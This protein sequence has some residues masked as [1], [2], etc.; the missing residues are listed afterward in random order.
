[1]KTHINDR[2]VVIDSYPQSASKYKDDYAIVCVD[3]IRSATTAITAVAKGRRCFPV[4]SLD[5]AIALSNAI[6]DDRPLLVGELGGRTPNGIGIANSPAAVAKRDDVERPLI[7]LSTSGT[8]LI[9]AAAGGLVTFLACLRNT[10]AAAEFLIGRYRKIAIIGAGTRNEFSEE[11]QICCAWMADILVRNGYKA[12]T[13]KTSDLIRQWKGVPIDAFLGSK[14][15]E[16]L[17]NSDQEEDIQFILSH[18]DDI[19]ASFLIAENEVLMIPRVFYEQEN[20]VESE[21]VQ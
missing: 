14:S 10:T 20:S 13:K 15:V 6:A 1:M 12:A 5:E 11:D 16:F 3:V 4:A 17:K 2:M 7:L 21:V 19:D 8:Q 9:H 18:V